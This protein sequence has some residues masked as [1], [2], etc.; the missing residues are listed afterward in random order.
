MNPKKGAVMALKLAFR[1]GKKI[2]TLSIILPIILLMIASIFNLGE[3]KWFVFYAAPT[4]A[5]ALYILIYH[6]DFE[7][8]GFMTYI[9][10]A[11]LAVFLVLHASS[12][13]GI[14]IPHK[15]FTPN[16]QYSVLICRHENAL[17]NT[18]IIFNKKNEEAIFTEGNHDE[19]CTHL[20]YLF[21]ETA[22]YNGFKPG[23]YVE[24]KIKEKKRSKFSMAAIVFVEKIILA[25]NYLFIPYLIIFYL[26]AFSLSEIKHIQ[27]FN[28]P[29]KMKK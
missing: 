24:Q 6:T 18:D 16:H 11:T 21:Y 14:K 10:V 7:S 15:L 29:S 23:K 1:L 9:F 17:E 19:E 5:I 25:L 12:Y 27:I 4:L 13:F 22:L 3:F 8:D 20:N 2:I 28:T 26:F